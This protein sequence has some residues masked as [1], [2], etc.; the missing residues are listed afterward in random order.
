MRSDEAAMGSQFAPAEVPALA[1]SAALLERVKGGEAVRTRIPLLASLAVGGVAVAYPLYALL[2]FPLRADLPGLPPLWF[3]TISK[4]RSGA[5]FA[6]VC[7]SRNA[8]RATKLGSVADQGGAT[9]HSV[10]QL[11]IAARNVGALPF[12]QRLRRV[13]SPSGRA[14]VKR[15]HVR[16]RPSVRSS[17]PGPRR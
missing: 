17:L 4:A 7:A 16:R 10:K 6:V 3:A 11:L 2:A 12:F 8:R 13:A 14:L 5:R 9:I 15:G 1:P